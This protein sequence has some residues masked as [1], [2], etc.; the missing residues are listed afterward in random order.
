M[1]QTPPMPVPGTGRDACPIHQANGALEVVCHAR[2][3]AVKAAA[4]SYYG[5]VPGARNGGEG[6]RSRTSATT[7]SPRPRTLRSARAPATRARRPLPDLSGNRRRDRP[8]TRRGGRPSGPAVL[9]A[10]I[11]CF[12]SSTPQITRLWGRARE[13]ISGGGVVPAGN[14]IKSSRSLTWRKVSV[15]HLVLCGFF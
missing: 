6:T 15:S 12:A 9:A 2:A 11:L 5:R 4:S 3:D 13:L 14:Q 1:H 7:E 10:G 8:P